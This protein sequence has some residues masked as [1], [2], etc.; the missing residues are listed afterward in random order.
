MAFWIAVAF[1]AAAVIYAVLRP[2]A[3]KTSELAAQETQG[4]SV[5]KDQLKEIDADQ[6]RGLLSGNEAEAMRAEVSRRL[7]RASESS[8]Q[9]GQPP[10]RVPSPRLNSIYYALTVILP[11]LSVGLYLS[12]GAP[13]M[14]AQPYAQRLKS[15]ADTAKTGDL[16]AQ[17]E[18][19]LR[20]HPEDGRG[21]DVV[22]PVY[23]AQRRFQDA[24]EAYA[25]ALRIL[26][27]TAARLEGFALARIR[28][29]NGLVAADARKALERSLALDGTRFEPR[30]W[31]ALAKEQDGDI[32]GAISDYRAMLA[33]APAGV[34]WRKAVEERMAGLSAKTPDAEKERG[35]SPAE[36]PP[37]SQDAAGSPS[38]PDAD[39][40]AALPPAERER[41][42]G[43]M[44]QR[45]ADRLN[46]D[47]NDLAGW[48]KLVRAY[49]VLE[50]N[51]E[52]SRALVDARKQFAGNA[53][54][55]DQ[56]DALA[57][58]LGVKP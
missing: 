29:G 3:F 57:R 8:A 15:S 7:I 48:L 4:L 24:A 40:I 52:V 46:K 21:W 51:D 47:G 27:E 10:D 19:R 32:A 18:A 11:L 12:Y 54:A 34:P 30:V 26:G 5:Y 43:T 17:V 49:K 16:I 39:A 41:M 36:T 55:L 25:A 9:G 6:K 23:M 38:R 28:G 1:L 58:E 56:L 33:S 31:L 2:L 37:P 22:A 50:R 35:S 13:G 53:P 45:L 42:I 20:D 14:P 44:V